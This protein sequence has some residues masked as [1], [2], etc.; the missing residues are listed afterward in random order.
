VPEVPLCVC[1]YETEAQLAEVVARINAAEA[2]GS[3]PPWSREVTHPAAMPCSW[4]TLVSNTPA[5][6]AQR[7]ACAAPR[8]KLLS[9]QEQGHASLRIFSVAAG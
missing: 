5:A 9:V 3:I 8:S 2:A 1:S 7:V 4:H 6:A